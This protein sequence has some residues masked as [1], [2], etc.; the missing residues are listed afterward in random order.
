MTLIGANSCSRVS[1]GLQL[2]R[3]DVLSLFD[4]AWFERTFAANEEIP[5][6]NDRSN[7]I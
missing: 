5:H 4:A 6:L 2:V 3:I 1:F 7:Q